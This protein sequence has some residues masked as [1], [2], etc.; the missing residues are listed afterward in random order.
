MLPARMSAAKASIRFILSSL[1][2]TSRKHAAYELQL[3]SYEALATHMP[4]GIVELS[5]DRRG[6]I[7]PG[8]TLVIF[9]Q[10]VHGTPA[11]RQDSFPSRRIRA[12]AAF[13]GDSG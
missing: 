1:V 4:S 6:L 13:V 7:A 9:S 2:A 3:K 5:G 8:P 10:T 11:M 12:R